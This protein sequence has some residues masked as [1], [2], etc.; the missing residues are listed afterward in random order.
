MDTSMLLLQHIAMLQ[1]QHT[2]AMHRRAFA[3]ATRLSATAMSGRRS[4]DSDGMVNKPVEMNRLSLANCV[5]RAI[6]LPC[7]WFTAL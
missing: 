4:Y 2:N 3:D 7:A 1:S 5:T 6:P